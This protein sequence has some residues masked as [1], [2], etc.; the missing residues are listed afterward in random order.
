MTI[1]AT[2]GDATAVFNARFLDAISH[3]RMF[4]IAFRSWSLFEAATVSELASGIEPEV[5]AASFV[6]YA[7]FPRRVHGEMG[8]WNRETWFQFH[9]Y[10]R[11]RCRRDK[12]QRRAP[13]FAGSWEDGAG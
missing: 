7:V 8:D 12:S 4:G 6:S 13:G 1:L 11:R 2:S 9:P 3:L 10:R 5:P